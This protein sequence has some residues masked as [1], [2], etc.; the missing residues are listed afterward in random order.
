MEK[1]A[2][3]KRL[4][5]MDNTI[6]MQ[7]IINMQKTFAN[8]TIQ[9]TD[10]RK[11]ET[12]LPISKKS[13]GNKLKTVESSELPIQVFNNENLGSVRVVMQDDI[14]WFVA[15]DICN[16]LGIKNTTQAVARLDK[17]EWSKFNLGRQGDTNCVNEYGL[18]NL[19]LTSRKPEAKQLMYWITK[20]VFPST[21]NNENLGKTPSTDSSS[22]QTFSNT[23]FGN[24]DVLMI[25]NKPY[26]PAT[27][28]AEILGHTNPER[29]V[30]NFC[31][32]V[33]VS[34]TPSLGGK[35]PTK[36]I[37]EGDLYRLIVRSNLPSAERFEKWVFDEVLPSIRKHG[38]YVTP[39]KLVEFLATPESMI[40]I[41]TALH[42]EQQARI[43]A[44]TKLNEAQPK[45]TFANAVSQSDDSIQMGVFV[46]FL[47]QNGIDIGRNRL[48]EWLR[49][50]N[51][52]CSHGDNRNLPTQSAMDLGL[53]RV[54]EVQY[55]DEFGIGR[56]GLTTMVT[57]KSQG[58]FINKFLCEKYS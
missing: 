51:Y 29:A 48:F 28:C 47:K 52:L 9:R 56:I 44:E 40:Q 22:V 32:G 17:D 11:P 26:F 16:C 25:D 13:K 7:E 55:I 53:F 50:N 12:P 5:N 33:T 10:V 21:F 57:P 41:F 45:I 24:L 39:E 6:N 38:V 4:D 8:A 3:S 54:K 18:Y 27:K 49:D 35:Q 43:K 58:Y 19:V 1:Q 37:P 15:S 31:R 23:E 46:K 36:Y 20:D 14:P 2:Q 42:N 30:R 34:V